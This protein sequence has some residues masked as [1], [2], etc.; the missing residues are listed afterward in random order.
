[1]KPGAHFGDIGAVIQAYAEKN[2]F[3]VVRE[4][5][6][7]GI[8]KIFHEPPNVLHYGTKGSGATLKPG[9]I[10]TIE[11]MINAGK[12]DVLVTELDQPGFYTF[13]GIIGDLR[14]YGKELDTKDILAISESSKTIA[15]DD[16]IWNMPVGSRNYVEEI[17]RFFKHKMPGNKSQFFDIKLTGLSITD[18]TVRDLIESSIKSVLTKIN[19]VHASLRNIVWE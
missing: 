18:T 6:G 12:R 14:I 16:L 5:C 11:P 4:Y 13:H 9:M 1:M 7:H 19:P 2:R 17:E 15:F 8:G 3:S 10:F